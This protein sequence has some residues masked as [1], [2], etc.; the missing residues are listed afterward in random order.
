MIES[1]QQRTEPETT[2]IGLHTGIPETVHAL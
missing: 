1:E 2:D